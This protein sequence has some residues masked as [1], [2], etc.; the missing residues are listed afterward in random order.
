[1]VDDADSAE[2]LSDEEA[3]APV[4]RRGDRDRFG[5]AFRDEDKRDFRK[6]RAGADEGRRRVLAQE[7]PGGLVTRR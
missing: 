1:M 2:S 6:P 4:V 7:L 3:V 5:E